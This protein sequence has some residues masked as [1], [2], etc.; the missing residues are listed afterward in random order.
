MTWFDDP[1]SGGGQFLAPAQATTF[2]SAR[3]V[4]LEQGTPEW[5]EWRRGGLGGSDIPTLMGRPSVKGKGRFSVWT[6]KMYGETSPSNG[7]QA[8]RGHYLESAVAKWV[9]D[10]LGVELLGPICLERI[11]RPWIRASLD[12]HFFRPGMEWAGPSVLEIKTDRRHEQWRHGPPQRVIDQVRWQMYV[13]DAPD[14]EIGVYL[15]IADEWRSWTIER[16]YEAEAELL[17][18]AERFWKDHVETGNPPVPD[19]SDECSDWLS[20]QFVEYRPR[21]REANQHEAGILHALL[22][23]RQ[24]QKWVAEN[25]KALANQA[26]AII[27][28]DEEITWPGGRA[29]WKADASGKRRLRVM[30]SD[31]TE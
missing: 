25:E 6:S 3:V 28:N 22:G 2:S 4:S 5:L 31:G 15:P 8:M 16:D 29:T 10:S 7:Q 12:N 11:D 30:A 21:T 27:G 20:E 19:S 13:A 18:V 26:K 14:A 23:A 17:D 1:V 9:A 24:M